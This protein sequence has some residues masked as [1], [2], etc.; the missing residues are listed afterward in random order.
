MQKN[1]EG[2]EQPIA[3]FSH[4][5]R[6]AE[7]K[8]NILKKQA[9]ALVKSLKAFRVYIL[10]SHITTFVPTTA[11]KDILIQGDR[12]KKREVD[13]QDTGVGCL[14]DHASTAGHR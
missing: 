12:R 9:Y 7:L 11:V 10:Q 6:D 14:R 8:Y 13:C 5:L 3:F 1:E 2:Y 4:V